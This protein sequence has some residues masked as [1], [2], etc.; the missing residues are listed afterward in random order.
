MARPDAQ[1]LDEPVVERTVD[2]ELK[3]ADAVGDMLN[4]VTLAVGVVVHRVDAPLVA[5]AVVVGMEDAVHDGVAEHHV[6]VRHVD[7]G[8]QH[9][10]AVGE[11][12]CTHAAEQV[13]VLLDRAVAVGAVLARR[14]H[15][16]APLANLV[17]GLVV[18]VSQ[19]FLYQEFGPLVELLEIVRGVVL[20]GPVEAQPVD[21]L[22]D[23]VDILGVLLHGVGVVEA[24]VGLAAVLLRQS[25]INAYRLGVADVQVAVGFRRKTG[26]DRGVGAILQTLFDNL[27]KK[28]KLLFRSVAF[29]HN[30]LSIFLL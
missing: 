29:F 5:R 10:A 4:A 30:N 14:G 17:E 23:G 12:A 16:A 28:I 6:G 15:R 18:D 20:L 24:Q 22:L 27:L 1:L 19:T 8:A 13:E 26:L 7:L 3:R 25:E 9:L 11:L 2:V 21:V